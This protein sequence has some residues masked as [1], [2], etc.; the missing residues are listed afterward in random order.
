MKWNMTKCP[1]CG[2]PKKVIAAWCSHCGL[3]D[4]HDYELNDV[5]DEA[6]MNEFLNAPEG[7]IPIKEVYKKHG[8]KNSLSTKVK[9]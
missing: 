3:L 1:Y 6:L 4:S 8:M 7:T 9:E 2:Q 5:F